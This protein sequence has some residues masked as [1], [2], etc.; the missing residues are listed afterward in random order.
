MTKLNLLITEKFTFGCFDDAANYAQE[1]ANQYSPMAYD[2]QANV[3]D[4]SGSFTGPQWTLTL[5][6]RSSCD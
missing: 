2:T 5:T 1:Y 3:E 4:T 6:R